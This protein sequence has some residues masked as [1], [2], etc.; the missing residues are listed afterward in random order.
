[1]RNRYAAQCANCG[2]WVFE[3]QGVAYKENGRWI[4]A[5]EFDQCPV[6]EEPAEVN[7]FIGLEL[8]RYQAAVRD[9]LKTG[10]RGR[11]IMVCARAGS[12]KTTVQCLSIWEVMMIDPA[13][14]VAMFAF[15]HDDGVRI[16]EKC[17]S[18]VDG[19]TTHSF[20]LRL[21]KEA[22]PGIKVNHK[23]TKMLVEE[24]CEGC[25]DDEFPTYVKELLSKAKADAIRYGQLVELDHLIDSYYLDI[26]RV[27]RRPAVEA[28]S[29]ALRLGMDLEE[30]G[31]NFDDMIYLMAILD[32]P[33]PEYDIVAVDEIQDWGLSQ[34]IF[35]S[36]LIKAGARIIAVGDPNQSLYLFRG[37]RPDSFYQVRRLLDESDKGVEDF[38]MPISYRSSKAII[39]HARQWIPE[40]QWRPDAPEGELILDFPEANLFD[41]LG[42][43]DCVISRTRKP[44]AEL[45]RQLGIAGREFYMR[46]GDK[47]AGWLNWL[48]GILSDNPDASVCTV[49]ELLIRLNE[50]LTARQGRCSIFKWAEYASRSEIITV[51]AKDAESVDD[52]KKR[53]KKLYKEPKDKSKCIILSTIHAA[54]GSEAE[55]IFHVNPENV[56]HPL[57]KTKEQLDQ[58]FN[59]AYVAITRGITSYIEVV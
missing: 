49:P 14:S 12:G 27:M 1:M 52:L 23:K 59:A 32:I 3:D 57:A 8:D 45:S 58:E 39:R 38:G 5:H 28:C 24:V 15:G 36:K 54:K 31:V 42:P 51:L 11:H 9:A 50:W 47:E 40:L 19:G 55:R 48:I 53:I 34:I 26:P 20:G 25:E 16:V 43:G 4:T 22:F 18:R 7:P 2:E 10:I 35:L 46:G 44:L 30:Y 29:R 6:K 13:L 37:A 33:V 17:P 21:L 56:P 41:E